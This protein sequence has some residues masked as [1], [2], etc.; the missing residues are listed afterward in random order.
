[1]LSFTFF[2]LSPQESARHTTEQ[3][4]EREKRTELIRGTRREKSILEIQV[5]MIVLKPN[6]RKRLDNIRDSFVIENR[7]VIYCEHASR[8]SGNLV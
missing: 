5:Q 2:L 3:G 1:M 8:N 4:N 7:L 6:L